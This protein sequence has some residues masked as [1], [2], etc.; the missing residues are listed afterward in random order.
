MCCLLCTINVNAS[1]GGS[2]LF[3]FAVARGPQEFIAACAAA[4]RVVDPAPFR[5]TE[6]DSSSASSAP[7][8]DGSKQP[9]EGATNGGGG[10]GEVGAATEA[11]TSLG[12]GGVL[13]TPGS[14]GVD[15]KPSKTTQRRRRDNFSAA[16]TASG[17][18]G[19][20]E[21]LV[22]ASP[23]KGDNASDRR[24]KRNR[25]AQERGGRGNSEDAVDREG[26]GR[27]PPEEPPRAA[28]HT[29]GGSRNKNRKKKKKKKKT[30]VSD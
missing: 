29:A 6:T 19:V 27:V 30:V 20:G 22:G 15:T 12:E 2:S 11:A 9:T 1:F 23:A 7:G 13:E 25:V 8:T 10:G 3:L 14:G 24:T 17:E 28:V 18:G 5:I 16:K 4:T 26:G 21:V